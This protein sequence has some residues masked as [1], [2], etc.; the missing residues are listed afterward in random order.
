MTALLNFEFSAVDWRARNH[1]GLSKN[2]GEELDAMLYVNDYIDGY[3]EM[4]KLTRED[5]ESVPDH[6]IRVK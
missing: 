2:A 4:G 5:A 6:L 1:L 3:A